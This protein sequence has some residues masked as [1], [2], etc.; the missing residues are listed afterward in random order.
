MN[1]SNLGQNIIEIGNKA[2][3]SFCCVCCKVRRFEQSVQLCS[4]WDSLGPGQ[5]ST[6]SH[7]PSNG[8]PQ[9]RVASLL[10]T[11]P[12]IGQCSTQ[13]HAKAQSS[14]WVSVCGST[15][16][17]LAAW[18]PALSRTSP[19]HSCACSYPLLASVPPQDQPEPAVSFYL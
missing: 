17:Y 7:C 5:V 9:F 8:S 3:G 10:A 13:L 4:E 16:G 6:K 11:F 19:V 2:C 18:N 1:P 15:N 12:F 14:W